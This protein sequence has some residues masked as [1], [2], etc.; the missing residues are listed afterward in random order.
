MSVL[1]VDS[2]VAVKW[3]LREDDTDDALGLFRDGLELHA[4]DLIVVEVENVLCKRLR[5]R[6]V[7][8]EYAREAR[9]TFREFPL[10]LH[11]TPEFL[12]L[13]FELA[14]SSAQSLYDCV[15]LALAQSMNAEMVTADRKFFEAASRGPL[16]SLVGWVGDI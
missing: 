11:H 13:A 8:L 6:E 2:S 7:S 12:D 5:R 1:V 16:S 10:R 3:L 14:I 4:P 9:R 15:F